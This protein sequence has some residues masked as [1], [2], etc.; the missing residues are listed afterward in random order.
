MLVRVNISHLEFKTF[1]QHISVILSQEESENF[2]VGDFLIPKMYGFRLNGAKGII[3]KYFYANYNNYSY[4]T[5]QK[6]NSVRELKVKT[7]KS[8]KKV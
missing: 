8:T 4:L 5:N 2:I 1:N 6:M 7:F 3:G